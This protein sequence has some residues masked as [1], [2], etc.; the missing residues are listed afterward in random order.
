MIFHFIDIGSAA[1]GFIGTL[2][3][4]WKIYA[5]EPFEGVVFGSPDVYAHNEKVRARNRS[6]SNWQRIGLGFLSLSFL[7]QMIGPFIR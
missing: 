7:L 2:I 4:F 6:R 5:F 3:L 1:L